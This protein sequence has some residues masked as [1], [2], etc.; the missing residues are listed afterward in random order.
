MGNA[1]LRRIG[2]VTVA[3]S[4]FGIYRPVLR[5]IQEDSR[6]GLWLYVTGMHLSERFGLTVREVE[7]EG[8]PVTERIPMLLEGDAPKDIALSMA[9]GTSGMAEALA[10][11]R[12]DILVVL[13]DRFEMHA[14]A[15]AAVPFNIPIAHIHGGE[16]SFGAI[17]DALRHSMTKLSHL[18]FATTE[19]SA[20]RIRQMGEEAWRITKSGAPGLDNL[21]LLEIPDPGTIE[22]EF[23]I[24]L[25]PPPL[26]VTYH[27][28]TRNPKEAEGEFAEL[29]KALDAIDVPVLFTLPNA[30][31]GN[32]HL[33]EKLR[34]YVKKS[35]DAWLVDNFGTANYFGAMRAAAAMVGNSSSGI[36][37]AASFK[38][39]V[40]NIGDRQKGRVRAANV[41]DARS[42][43]GA[44]RQSIDQALSPEFRRSL[45]KLKNT[46]GDGR[47]AG[48]IVEVLRTIDIDQRLIAKEFAGP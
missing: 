24:R 30:D 9:R 8:F 19:E 36:I 26:L 44:I 32:R 43:E 10:R 1:D 3:R 13:G 31:P 35:R 38:L 34:E 18:H 7:A 33:I 42:D 14:A 48:K 28:E 27:P 47:A 40:V 41:I 12:P 23:Q 22:S 29:L 46:Y 21:L 17:D 15:V 2:V 37:E 16:L 39:P 4:D 20:D 6:L 11:H 25:D 45:E 5:A